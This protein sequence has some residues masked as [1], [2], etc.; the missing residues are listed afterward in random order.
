MVMCHMLADTEAEL[1]AMADRL[2]MRREWYQPGRRPH[3]DLSKTRRAEAM[4]LGAIEVTSRELVRRFPA[5]AGVWGGE[6]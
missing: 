4:R 2:G 1:H 5:G 6:G 3:Y